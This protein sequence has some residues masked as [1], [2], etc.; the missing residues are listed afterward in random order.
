MTDAELHQQ[1]QILHGQGLVSRRTRGPLAIY[2]YTA[3]AQFSGEWTP[4]LM[5]ARGL[6]FEESTRRVVARPFPKFFNVG[7][8]PEVAP[9][10][11]P[12][13]LPHEVTEKID[14]SLG[15]LFFYDGKWDVATRGAFESGQAVYARERLLPRLKLDALPVGMTVMT[16]IVYPENRIVVDYGEHSFLC[17]IAARDVETGRELGHW[18]LIQMGIRAGMESYARR[19]DVEGSIRRKFD[20]GVLLVDKLTEDASLFAKNTEGYVIRWPLLDLRVKIKSPDYVAAHRLLDQVTPRRALELIRDGKADDIRSQLPAHVRES[21]DEVADGIRGR[22]VNRCDR[23]RATFQRFAKELGE[24][25]KSFA[26]AIRDEPP[27]IKALAFAL[28]DGSADL[29]PMACD[30]LAKELKKETP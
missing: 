26:L 19:R 24:S 18:E 9:W 14:G 6:I 13:H 4:A 23:A 3:T 12:W 30:L 21:F 11:L 8:R 16:E 5:A 1:L 29:F 17:L 22:I 25:R 15:I 28:A 7:E 10:V 2:N 20:T 27:A